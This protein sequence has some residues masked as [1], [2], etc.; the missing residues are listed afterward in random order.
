MKTAMT[1]LSFA[2]PALLALGMLMAGAP[3]VAGPVTL[4]A[5]ELVALKALVKRDGAAAAQFAAVRKTALAARDDTPNPIVLVQ[6]E[7][8]LKSDKR[9]A[10]TAEAL[11]DMKKAEALAWAWAVSGDE[12]MGAK[13]REFILAWASVNKSD[14]N[15][16]NETNFEPMIEAYD[17]VR[18]EM[19][20]AARAKVDAW[21]RDKAT[22]LWDSEQG[23][24]ENWQSHRIKIVGL[25]AGT[26][27]DA[28]L[29]RLAQEGF[30]QQIQNGFEAG[31]ASIDFKRRD[32]MHYHLYS[33]QPL[34]TLACVAERRDA[35]MFTYRARNGTSLANAVEFMEPYLAG[36]KQHTEFRNSVV[37]FDQKRAA[38]GEAA[39]QPHTWQPKSAVTALSE[40][41][42][43]D[44]KYDRLARQ[45]AGRPDATYANWRAVLN[46][47]VAK[48]SPAE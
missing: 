35:P 15:P 36:A 45:A 44:A 17:L 27:G 10:R 12:Q 33:I 7:G 34:L 30:R 2:L 48:H 9:K 1:P 8:L 16:I 29:W 19:P 32:A 13:A 37:N 39:Y 11:K 25:I 3:A 28:R 22:V 47:V 26:I 18:A 42:C 38:A 41:G 24:K 5:G 6:S 46:A 4:D 40:A 31:G 43:L 14:G 21:L 20:A 23:R